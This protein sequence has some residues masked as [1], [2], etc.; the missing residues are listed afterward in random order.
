VDRG[1]LR[2]AG[3]PRRGFVKEERAT[4][5]RCSV[6]GVAAVVWAGK[7]VFNLVLLAALLAALVPLYCI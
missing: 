1:L 3:R 6:V 5:R 2:G 7:L 4:P